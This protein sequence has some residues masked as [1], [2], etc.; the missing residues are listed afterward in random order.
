M[1]SY[2]KNSTSIISEI[3]LCRISISCENRYLQDITVFFT[4][5]FHGSFNKSKV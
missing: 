5:D 3:P 2:H 4:L 1:V